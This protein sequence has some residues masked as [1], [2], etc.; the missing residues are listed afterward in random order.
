MMYEGVLLFGVVFLAGLVFDVLT[1]SRNALMLRHV[2]QGVLF[3]AIGLYFV[4]CWRLKGQ[5]LPMKTWHIRLI[6][7]HGGIP[8][9]HVLILRYLLA[10]PLPLI[11]AQIVMAAAQATGYSSTDMFIVFA[12]FAG[13]IWAWFDPDGQFVHDRL[14]GTRLVDAPKQQHASV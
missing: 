7:R 1:D 12:P 6:D 8:P 13:F 3:F 2:R 5:T 11:A 9:L 10:W 4:I 14:L